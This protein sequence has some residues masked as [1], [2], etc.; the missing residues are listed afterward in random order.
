[1][2]AVE[3][4]KLETARYL[5]DA[6][7]PAFILPGEPKDFEPTCPAP[8]LTLVK[9]LKT[10]PPRPMQAIQK[11]ADIRA[12]LGPRTLSVREGNPTKEVLGV[13]EERFV[14]VVKQREKEVEDLR[15]VA[16]MEA[17][18]GA[19]DTDRAV[20]EGSSAGLADGD[21]EKVLSEANLDPDVVP[22]RVHLESRAHRAQKMEERARASQ[23][24]CAAVRRALALQA[25][26][27]LSHEGHEVSSSFCASFP[28]SQHGESLNSALRQPYCV[29][30]GRLS[31]R[32]L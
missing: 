10:L 12:A 14:N 27:L 3:K 16:R 31:F 25:T 21:L 28:C 8:S 4:N 26:A 19:D 20:K 22:K 5:A 7:C 15:K 29:G 1:M 13:K 32:C 11:S 6:C 2:C 30:N 9:F 18:D 24:I 23:V 17:A